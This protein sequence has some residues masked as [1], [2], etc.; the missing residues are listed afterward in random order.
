MDGHRPQ[1]PTSGNFTKCSARFAGATEESVEAF[2]DNVNTYKQC[3][4]TSDTNAVLGLTML[5]T[6]EAATWWYGVK[7]SI[8][9]WKDA[10]AV[11]TSAFGANLPPHQI[12]RKLFAMEHDCNTTTEIFISRFRA[13]AAKLHNPLDDITLLDMLYGGLRIEIRERIPRNN[14]VSFDDLIKKARDVESNLVETK[15]DSK[16]ASSNSANTTKD[17]G[18]KNGRSKTRPYCEF[19]R[20]IGHSSE[21]CRSKPKVSTTPTESKAPVSS[22]TSSA[23]QQS[24]NTITCYSCGQPGHLSS[25]CPSK[26]SQP[27]SFSAIGMESSATSRMVIPISIEGIPG[28]ALIDNG[29]SRSVM[30]T[31][32][33]NALLS[34]DFGFKES[35]ATVKLAQGPRRSAKFLSSI[36]PISLQSKT[37]DVEMVYCPENP[38]NQTCLGVDF[39]A[40]ADI[41]CNPKTRKWC[42]RSSSQEQFPLA[43][44]YDIAAAEIVEDCL[45]VTTEDVPQVNASDLQDLNSLITSF[46]DVFAK[47]GPPTDLVEHAIELT[48]A[49]PIAQPPYRVNPRLRKEVDQQIKDLLENDIIEECES[50]WSAPM[51]IVP[52]KTG[53][54]RL[55]VDYRRLNSVTVPDRYPLPLITDLIN[56][57]KPIGFISLLDLRSGYHQV[58]VKESDQ[59]K[60]AFITESGLF[61]FKRMPFGLRNAP[62]TFQRLVDKVK[63]MA[64]DV[65]MFAYLD[66]IVVLSSTFQEHLNDLKTI[67][68]IARKHRLRIH[69]AK[70][71]FCCNTIKYLG[72]VISSDGIATDPSKVSSIL[73]MKPPRNPKEVQTFLQT[74]SWYRRFIP[75]FSEVARPLSVL[76]KQHTPWKWEESEQKSFNELKRLLTASPIL[77][78]PDFDQPF[79]VCCDA[80]S[81]AIGAALLQGND[82][83]ERPIEFAS[84]LL[85]SAE[86]NYSA[87]DREA[88]AVVWALDKFRSYIERSPVTVYTDHQALKWLMTLKAPAG[89]LARWA[90]KL[91][92]YDLDIQYRPGNVN[93]V[94][95]TLSR[96]PT[97][98][99]ISATSI[100][101]IADASKIRSMQQLDPELQQITA[102]FEN[103]SA[104]P[105]ESQRWTSKGYIMSNGILYKYDTDGDGSE[106]QMVASKEMIKD[107]MQEFHDAETAGHYGTE[108]TLRRISSRYYWP[109]MKKY[110]KDYVK[111]C[112]NCQKYKP[113]N[114]MPSGLVQI[115]PPQ[116]RFMT[117][118][119]DLFG[120]L[121]T[122]AQGNRWIFVTE[123]VATKWVELFPLADAT[124]ENCAR[125]IVDEICLRYGVPRKMISDNGPQFISQ[126]VQCVTTT[127]GIHQS[128][129]PVYHPEANPVERKNR[130]LKTQLAIAVGEEHT[131]WD[132]HLPA[133]RFSMNTAFCESIGYAPAYLLFGSTIRAP[134]DATRDLREVIDHNVFVPTITPYLKSL[135]TIL[136]DAAETENFQKD[137]RT[138]QANQT[139]AASPQFKVGDLVLIKTHLHSSKDAGQSAKFYPKR[140]GPYKIKDVNSPT[141]YT[142]STEADDQVVG[143][144]H[145]SDLTLFKG[146]ATPINPIRKRGRPRKQR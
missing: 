93:V 31:S 145:V 146:K 32:L 73:D 29:A 101:L 67:F 77:R 89:R 143:K 40:L 71:S 72:H 28:T 27:A 100:S 42:F 63:R 41:D 84:R 95:D 103:P 140:D 30:S 43:E 17:N 117:L 44:E 136:A 55:C 130:E 15:D 97:D 13:M 39:L 87:T 125:L 144:Y 70:C 78:Q 49:T 121:P 16:S 57:I 56:S 75:K 7:S 110:I 23:A 116:R 60:T 91:Q 124:A 59:P 131:E 99:A 9:T 66:D 114:L 105:L 134:G 76:T 35:I 92:H 8:S 11:L 83:D 20:R 58:P 65:L 26:S 46:R 45:T 112:V 113:S 98:L 47:H 82:K 74:C 118:A 115:T 142:L 86:V 132:T 102:V 10:E 141:S 138:N 34:L 54:I 19:H 135:A 139:R 14:V 52:K 88:L 25:S 38:F 109:G 90:L 21:N 53:E 120:P 37:F 3:T 61:K 6:G 18:S 122:T 79:K 133:I 5:L 50:A 127:L 2:L 107:I 106:G 36:V 24:S 33:F 64:K 96:P 137:R 123:D 129:I 48:S 94:A 68:T 1:Q 104:D 22:T 80:S 126:V 81:Y 51:V 111:N 119:V 108:R 85:T 62:A 4:H 128:L 12:F 69:R